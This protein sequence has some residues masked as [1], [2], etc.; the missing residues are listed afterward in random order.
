MAKGKKS[1]GRKKG[2]RNK[3]TI[4]GELP[5]DYEMAKAVAPY[6]HPRLATIARS[7]QRKCNRRGAR[8]LRTLS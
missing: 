2:S 6:I 7:A 8:C 5:R 1:R 3:S 4:A